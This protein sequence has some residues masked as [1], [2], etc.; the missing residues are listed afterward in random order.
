M[1]SVLMLGLLLTLAAAA[2]AQ[3]AWEPEEYPISYWVGPPVDRNTLADWQTVKEAHFT[4]AGPGWG[5]SVEENRKMLDF[6]Q[7]VGLKALVVDSRIAMD[8]TQGDGWQGIL[9]QVVA[10]YGDHPALYGYYVQDE[11]NAEWFASLGQIVAEFRRRDPR[12]LAYINLFPTYASVLQ[13]GTPTYADHLDRFLRIVRPQVLSYDHYCLLQG[14]RDRPDYFENLELIR[15]YGLRYGVPPWNI[16]LSTPHL[17]YRDPTP[18]EMRW[19]VYTSLAYGMKGLMYFTYWGEDAIVDSQGRPTAHY[20]PIQQLNAEME[21][22]GRLLLRLESVGVFHT[23]EVPLGGRRLGSDAL[24]QV[25]QEEPLVVGFFRSPGGE[26]YALM[27]NRDYRAARTLTVRAKPHVVGVAAVSPQDGGEQELPLRDGTFT[28]SLAPGDG[29][30][31]RLRTEF[32]YP[33]PPKPL[34]EIHFRFDTDGDAE[35]W[36]GLNSLAP[37][38]VFGG[39][40]HTQV[41]GPDP[42]LVRPW[43]RLEPDQYTRIRVRLRVPGATQGQL[44]WTTRDEPGFAD[45]KYLNFPLNGGEEFQEVV[46]P[47]GEHPKWR[48]QAIRALRLDPDASGVPAGTAVEI[49]EVVGER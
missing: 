10:D 6:C 47:V 44:F 13:L 5:Y 25:S 23:G 49:D 22:L 33:E 18:A 28:L 26:D 32:T 30:L 48:G 11:P 1:Q 9:G 16:I 19:Q 4:V 36:G 12:H 15:E 27:V 2:Q 41:T 17:G 8:M 37:L 7:Q 40:L 35:G 43:L 42:Y 46:I 31:L 24:L 39:R 21:G 45:D 20:A 14:D 38:Q 29:R 34:T 3:T